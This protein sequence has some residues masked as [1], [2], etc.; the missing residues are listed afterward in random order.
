MKDIMLIGSKAAKIHFPDFP[1]E[2]HDTDYISENEIDKADCHYC[3]GF[4]Y[5]L[6]KY[7]NQDV[8]PPEVLYT[9]KVSH[10]FWDIWWEKTMFDICFFQSKKVNLD[11]DLFKVLYKDWEKRHGKKK[12]YL[13]KSNEDFF[14]DSVQ[15]TYIHDD[16][17][18]A[19]AYGNEP[20]YEKIKH[21]RSKAMTSYDL[22][23]KLN[24]E[25]KLNLC[26][27]EIYVTALERIL[28][29]NEFQKHPFAAFKE[30]AK[31][32]ITSMT[33]G[34]FP[35]FIVENWLKIRTFK[36]DYVAKFKLKLENGEVRLCN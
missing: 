27:E 12:A 25:E 13:K 5:I 3:E 9:L 4:E 28:V 2:P 26:R 19:I 23:L 10:A 21:D 31:M 29:P 22:F 15:R 8:A 20:L 30:A 32:L 18:K 11:E 6:N 36:Y 34:W 7:P 35:K 14:I 16:I 33:K 1:R 24:D 17:H